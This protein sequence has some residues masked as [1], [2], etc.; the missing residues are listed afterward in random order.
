MTN[1]KPKKKK[2]LTLI[3]GKITTLNNRLKVIR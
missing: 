1:V 2:K 3:L